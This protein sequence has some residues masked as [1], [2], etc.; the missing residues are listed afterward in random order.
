MKKTTLLLIPLLLVAAGCS[1][2]DKAPSRIIF[3]TETVN[4]SGIGGEASISYTIENPAEGQSLLPLSGESWVG[5]FD[6]ASEGIITF[7]VEQNTTEK[8]REALVEV[9]YGASKAYFTVI[10]GDEMLVEGDFS[11]DILG[12]NDYAIRCSISPKTEGTEYLYGI[13]DRATYDRF[14]SDDYF[15]DYIIENTPDFADRKVS[16]DTPEASFERL[17]P[18]TQYVVYCAGIDN[19]GNNVTDVSLL[20]FTTGAP[21]TFRLSQEIDGA[22]ANLIVTPSYDDR[23]YFNYAFTVRECGSPDSAYDYIINY[24][25]DECARLSWYYGMTAQEY[26]ADILTTGQNSKLLELNKLDDYYAIAVAMD[27]DCNPTSEM[28]IAEFSTEE[29]HPSDN[30]I[31]I[32][33]T[34]ITAI[35]AHWKATTTNDDQYL[36]FVEAVDVINEM[37]SEDDDELMGIIASLFPTTYY[38]RRGSQE[39]N[40]TNLEPNTRYMAFAFGCEAYTPTTRLFKTYFTTQ[41]AYVGEVSFELI[42]DKY[43]DGAELEEL[44]PADFAGASGNAVLP[45][46]AYTEKGMGFYYGIYDGDY[47]DLEEWPDQL[48]IDNLIYNGVT[49]PYG[50]YAIP[51][52]TTR[53]ALGVAY[54]AENNFG[55]VFRKLVYCT[56]DGVT[57]A[58]DYAPASV[59]LP[60]SPQAVVSHST[61]LDSRPVLEKR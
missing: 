15:W 42:F 31:S 36:L 56:E 29:V 53:T 20:K 35:G 61:L 40:V 46:R 34:D 59:K 52:N 11:I 43:Y 32:D 23:L 49:E 1:K 14:S 2:E 28:A 13:I 48:V 6:T 41:E 5:D 50:N 57:P 8:Q 16:G 45:V 7:K 18:Q 47:T 39:G 12:L 9:S 60:E 44:Y 10:Q 27:L 3:E 4:V 26:M 21:L 19:E 22:F 37:W 25:Q 24:I 58:E 17:A 38:G 30:L 51:Y 55:T 33:I 54:D